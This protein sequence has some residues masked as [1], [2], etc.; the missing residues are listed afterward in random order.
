MD[1]HTSKGV[2]FYIIIYI[3]E[4]VCYDVDIIFRKRCVM[5]GKEDE[6]DGIRGV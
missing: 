4:I 6:Y 3:I 5:Y 1:E 2:C